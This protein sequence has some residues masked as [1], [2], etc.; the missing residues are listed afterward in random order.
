MCYPVAGLVSEMENHMKLSHLLRIFR[1]NLILL[2]LLAQST[3]FTSPAHA[4]TIAVNTTVD[5]LD[6]DGNCSLREAIMSANSDTA[7]D[8][9]T[10][11]S[12][13]DTITVPAGTYLLTRMGADE[14]TNASG[15]LD[16]SGDLTIVGAGSAFTFIDGNGTDRVTD[17]AMGANVTLERLT[18]TNGF[19]DGAMGGG[20]RNSG[21][22][23]LDH[24]AVTGNVDFHGCEG[25]FCG[26]GGGIANAGT[27]TLENSSVE[28]NTTVNNAECCGN[29]FGA[30]GIANTGTLV[31]DQST[32]RNNEGNGII[33]TD[34]AT[35]TDST[36]SGNHALGCDGCGIQNSGTLAL[37]R[38]TLSGNFG[39]GES[40]STFGA[41]IYN[42]GTAAIFNST[43]SGNSAG[44]GPHGNCACG[45]GILNAGTMTLNNSTL[46]FNVAARDCSGNCLG[47]T[48]GGGLL[49]NGTV[50]LSNSILAFNTESSDDPQNPPTLTTPSDCAGTLGS[51]GYNL[52][53]T[54]AGCT[55]AGDTT[56]NL[57]GVDP[58][59]GPLQDNGG[60]T[61]THALP[62]ASPAIDTGNPV[63]TGS[64][65]NACLKTD[66]RNVTRPQD[67][68]G[69]GVSRCDIGAYEAAGIPPQALLVTVN[70]R[71]KTGNN[72]I[73]L[74][75][76]AL[77]PV[78]IL[79]TA[80]FDATTIDDSSLRFGPAGAANVHSAEPDKD[81]NGDGRLDLLLHFRVQ[82]TGIKSGDSQACLTGETLEGRLIEGCDRIRVLH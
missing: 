56:G 71:P 20:I 66:Q 82:Q 48:R 15:D 39:G 19:L 43:I 73:N 68:N 9:C 52:V 41:G 13:A 35:L 24:V 65:G 11:G 60:A 33:T 76:N 53:Q 45:G 78:A 58:L 70:I 54:V 47:Q 3:I 59:L 57:T 55:I 22:L 74:K 61:F 10:A 42:S 21:T 31:L 6:N 5:E 29:A 36:I 62:E 63:K 40:F 77:I 25:A 30:G 18:L 38:S 67:G 50:N 32:V 26:G 64:G 37:A 8:A 44:V 81:M 72:V 4:A 12:G 69:D 46:A 51:Q 16:L 2:M 7:F 79:S 49:N 17:V 23:S 80:T 34:R 1:A 14:D 75:S 28:S 27:L